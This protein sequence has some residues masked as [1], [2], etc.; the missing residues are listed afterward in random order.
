MSPKILA[1]EF[2]FN[3][4][5]RGN[6]GDRRINNIIRKQIDKS[7]MY[8]SRTTNCFL[9]Q[10]NDIKTNKRRAEKRKGKIPPV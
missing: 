8:L 10:V 9:Q 4:Q 5:F 1:F 6:I 3:F 7:S 2:R